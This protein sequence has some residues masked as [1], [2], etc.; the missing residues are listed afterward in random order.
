MAQRDRELLDRGEPFGR[1]APERP[2]DDGFDARRNVG[3]PR[4][5]RDRLLVDAVGAQP[6]PATLS[7]VSAPTGHELVEHRREPVL[8]R[9]GADRRPAAAESRCRLLGRDVRRRAEELARSGQARGRGVRI[10][11]PR[12]PEVR[13]LERPPTVEHEVLGL[14]VAVQHAALVHV[15]QTRCGRHDGRDRLDEGH[16]GG[17]PIGERAPGQQLHHE[18]PVVAVL[19][20]VEDT[21]DVRMV[22]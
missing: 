19:P 7:V 12:D 2:H 8:V 16:A 9:G 11:A 13:D 1:I 15:V 20:V 21:D 6:D 10:V 4:A 17:A 3:H 14:H 22:E 5:Q 18:Q